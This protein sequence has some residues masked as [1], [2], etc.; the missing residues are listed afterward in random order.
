MFEPAGNI[1]HFGDV[2]AGAAADAV[3]LFGNADEDSFHVEKF[4][5]FIELLGFG[6]GGAVVGFAG[7]D[8][9]RSLDL[10]DEVGERTLHVVVGVFPRKTGEPILGDERDV[11]RESEAVPIDDRIE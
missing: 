5:R 11:G 8:Q 4:Q 3:G 10:G 2:M 9:R 6:N 1:E 7:H